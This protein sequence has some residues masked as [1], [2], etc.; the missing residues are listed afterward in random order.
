[1]T[2]KE[3]K[4]ATQIPAMCRIY[5][6][7]LLRQANRSGI[8]ASA[9]ELQSDQEF[10][11]ELQ[12]DFNYGQI[13]QLNQFSSNLEK[14]RMIGFNFR[15]GLEA[16]VM[17]D[18]KVDSALEVLFI[19]D[20]GI[21]KRKRSEAMSRLNRVKPVD[22]EVSVLDALQSKLRMKKVRG[23]LL[24]DKCIIALQCLNLRLTRVLLEVF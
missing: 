8:R 6:K 23:L 15:E 19:K 17:T 14:L 11:S 13:L 10:I 9:A 7:H 18:N 4:Q 2:D 20:E 16:L 3:W 21:R 12:R 22:V 1:M 24:S 5:L